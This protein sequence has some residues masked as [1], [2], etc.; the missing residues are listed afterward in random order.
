MLAA[1]GYAAHLASA[2]VYSHVP[3]P[4]LIL[5]LCFQKKC[6]HRVHFSNWTLKRTR[7][8]VVGVGHEVCGVSCQLMTAEWRLFSSLEC[9][10]LSS[11]KINLRRYRYITTVCC[12]QKTQTKYTLLIRYH[13]I[14]H[15]RSRK[16]ASL[17]SRQG[18]P[19]FDNPTA[20]FIVSGNN[21]YEKLLRCHHGRLEQ[22]RRLLM[23]H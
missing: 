9:N 1:A 13:G 20:F 18:P 15:V 21:S 7:M 12:R 11:L 17:A 6:Y 8:H 19:I 5:L 3:Q 10:T 16:L 23:L 14:H 22:D 4:L 2:D